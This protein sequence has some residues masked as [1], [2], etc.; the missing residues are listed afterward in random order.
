VEEMHAHIILVVKSLESGNSKDRRDGSV[1][2][3]LNLKKS[4]WTTGVR[5][6][7][8]VAIFLLV[9]MFRMVL[10]P[11]QPPIQHVRE[12]LSAR[13]KRPERVADH[14]PPSAAEVIEYLEFYLF[15][16]YMHSWHGA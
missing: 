13:V 14:S 9:T 10:N 7:A 6:P 12:V 5:F 11:T 16:V 1:I 8:E 15:S 4:D 2:L 3:K